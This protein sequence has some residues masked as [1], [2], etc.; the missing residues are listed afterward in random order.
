MRVMVPH[1]H[2]ALKVVLLFDCT[3]VKFRRSVSVNRE[4][5]GYL[6]TPIHDFIYLN[7]MVLFI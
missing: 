2:C 5:T 7:S 1:I 6:I 4:L 3:E